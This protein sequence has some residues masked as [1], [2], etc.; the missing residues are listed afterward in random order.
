M[1]HYLIF[2]VLSFASRLRA[3]RPAS[4]M[5][6]FCPTG[7]AYSLGLWVDILRGCT[8]LGETRRLALTLAVVLFFYPPAGGFNQSKNKKEQT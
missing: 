5:K 3:E 8:V 7:C 6:G 4:Q 2:L 1:L